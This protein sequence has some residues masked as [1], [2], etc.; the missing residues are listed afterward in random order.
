VNCY[1]ISPCDFCFATVFLHMF[2]FP[3]LSL[4]NSFFNIELVENSALTFPTCFFSISFHLFCFFFPKIV[5]FCFFNFCVFFQ[6]CFCWFYFFNKEL[7]ENWAL[8]FFSLKHC[9]LLQCFLTWFFFFHFFMIVF[10]FRIVFVDFFS[11]YWA[12]WEFSF[13]FFFKQCGLLQCSSAWF[14]LLWFFSKLSLSILLFLIL[15][16]LRI[17]TIDFLMKHYRLLQCF[18]T[19]FFF[20]FVFFCY[21]FFSK[22]S[23]F[24]LFFKY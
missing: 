8:Y 3:K 24:I 22:F 19:W 16:W 9:G 15:S 13:V 11:S 5:F 10:F 17:T 6:N 21:D 20:L 18:P 7:V 4:S 23:L 2:F 14:F 12:D 1:N